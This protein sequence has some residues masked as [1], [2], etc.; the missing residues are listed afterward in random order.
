MANFRSSRLHP[1][2]TH[3]SA[4]LYF[5]GGTAVWLKLFLNSFLH[6]ALHD[7][8]LH[9]FECLHRVT[10]FVW[11]KSDSDMC[12]K[13]FAAAESQKEEKQGESV[14]GKVDFSLRVS[15][16]Q[17]EG[18]LRR[19]RQWEKA[20]WGGGE[21]EEKVRGV[22]RREGEEEDMRRR[23]FADKKPIL[24]STTPHLPLCGIAHR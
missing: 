18:E 14:E 10:C 12:S 8:L 9:W 4:H 21:G 20:I 17:K 1:T 11:V 23:Q 3:L 2:F 5:C 13:R 7:Y 19:R 16:Q 6:A 22:W 15:W 24:L